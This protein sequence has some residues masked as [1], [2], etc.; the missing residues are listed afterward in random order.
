M[1]YG[2]YGLANP[3]SSCMNNVISLSNSLIFGEVSAWDP[4]Q[5]SAAEEKTTIGEFTRVYGRK[6]DTKMKISTSRLTILTTPLKRTID[7]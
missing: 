6:N 4:R 3:Q 7:V 1:I 5:L 2:H